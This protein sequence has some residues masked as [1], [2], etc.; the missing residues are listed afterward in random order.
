MKKKKEIGKSIGINMKEEEIK[1]KVAVGLIAF[2]S[3]KIVIEVLF[4]NPEFKRLL[5][6]KLTWR[7]RLKLLKSWFKEKVVV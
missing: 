3:A 7:D 5:G 6:L 2:I 1:Q 4:N